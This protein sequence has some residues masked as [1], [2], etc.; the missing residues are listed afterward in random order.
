MYGPDR[1]LVNFKAIIILFGPYRR[2]K[3]LLGNYVTIY[4]SKQNLNLL[5]SK[6][7]VY[8]ENGN[9]SSALAAT[10][11]NFLSIVNPILHLIRFVYLRRMF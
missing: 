10:D 2:L 6:K 9:F 5:S 11:A 4:S 8:R 7:Y 3:L 1:V